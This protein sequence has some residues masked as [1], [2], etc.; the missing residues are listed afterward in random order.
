MLQGNGNLVLAGVL[1]VNGMEPDQGERD[2]REAFRQRSG[3]AD[4]HN[5]ELG[6]HLSCQLRSEA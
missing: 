6:W 4:R 1:R 2:E 5:R 3:E